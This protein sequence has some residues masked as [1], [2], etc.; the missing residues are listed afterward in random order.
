METCKKV[1]FDIFIEE[2]SS[3][4]WPEN[5]LLKEHLGGFGTPCIYRKVFSVFIMISSDF[6]L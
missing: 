3:L 5:L 4:N 1:S 2:R 6:I